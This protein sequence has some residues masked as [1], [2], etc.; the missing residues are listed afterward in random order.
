VAVRGIEFEGVTTVSQ[1]TGIQ[2]GSERPGRAIAVSVKTLVGSGDAIGRL[3]LPFLVVGV[4]LNILYPSAFSVGGPPYALRW[5]SIAVLIVGITVW[6]W[7][8]VLILTKVPKHELITSGPFS[9]AKHPLYTGVSLL[10]IPWLGFLLDTWLGVV[11]GIVMYI[12]SRRYAPA[13]EKV[14]AETFGVDW[15]EYC[16][17]VKMPWL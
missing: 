17:S 14:L 13:E 10:V 15:D 8:V 4:V 3:V 7:S 5:L 11:I 1:A 6:A 12:G 2:A 16:G 9:L